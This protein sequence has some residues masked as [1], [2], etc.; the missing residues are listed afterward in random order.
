MTLI[1]VVVVNQYWD[2]N[3]EKVPLNN[4]VLYSIIIWLNMSEYE[5][6]V[7]N[8]A[9]VMKW[10]LHN[11]TI[12]MSSSWW[13]GTDITLTHDSHINSQRCNNSRSYENHIYWLHSF[14]YTTCYLYPLVG[15]YCIWYHSNAALKFP[16]VMQAF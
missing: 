14:T 1:H 2:L 5:R 12:D 9:R 11:S 10:L 7:L 8:H 16:Y 3:Q 4:C 15:N 13:K 6:G